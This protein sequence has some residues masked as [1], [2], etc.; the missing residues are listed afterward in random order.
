MTLMGNARSDIYAENLKLKF[1][2]QGHTSGTCTKFQREILIRS[3]ILEIHKFRDNILE[4]SRNVSK[5]SPMHL[6][7]YSIESYD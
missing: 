4:S 6:S 2:A 5:T 1:C 7:N 3:T